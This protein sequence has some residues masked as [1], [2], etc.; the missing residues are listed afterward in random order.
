MMQSSN[1]SSLLSSWCNYVDW[2]YSIADPRVEKW[3]FMSSHWPSLIIVSAY[4]GMVKWGPQLMRHKSPLHLKP[5]M[6][7]YNLS[8]SALNAYI[9]KQ[10]YSA[11]TALGYSYVCQEV[12]YSYHPEELKMASTVWWFYFSK[13]IE[14]ADTVFLIL[15]KKNNQLSF[16]HVY[17]HATMILFWYIGARWVAGGS[18]FFPMMTN[19]FI[20]VLMY[21]YYGLA[22]L[23][24]NVQRFLWWKPYLTQIQMAQFLLGLYFAVQSFY[25]PCRFPL[26]M[27][28]AFI[29]YMVSLLAL[30]AN[31]YLKRY[32]H[33]EPPKKVDHVH[34][35][36]ESSV[37]HAVSKKKL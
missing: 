26:W 18:A 29:A 13:I 27:K 36:D 17:H 22:A 28:L 23:G 9:C 25:V 15:R 11:A 14:M 4:L 10:S 33:G 19:S 32:S 8:I 30:F 37:T 3:L 1:N 2:L 7:I 12:V 34:L 20:H 24:P 5:L 31:F 35:T 16:L 6:I 21:S